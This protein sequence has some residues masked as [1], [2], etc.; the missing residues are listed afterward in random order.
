MQGRRSGILLHISSLPSAYGVGDLGPSAYKFVDFLSETKQNYWQI[1]PLNPTDSYVDNSPYHS[2]SAFAFNPL[3]ISP[4]IMVQDGLL[5]KADLEPVPAFPKGEIDYSQ[6][7]A[8]KNKLFQKAYSRFSGSKH[9]AF[10]EFCYENS[11]WL[12]DY[13]LFVALKNH[14]GKKNWGEWPLDIRTRQKQTI[15]SMKNELGDA[16]NK[17]KFLQY[18]FYA[19]WKA[20]KK[21]C[22]EKGIHIVGDIPIYVTYDSA[23]IWTNRNLFK[24]DENDKPLYVAGVPPDYFSKTGQLWGN[25]VYNWEMLKRT[26]YDWWLNR[27]DHN[28]HL[29]DVIRIDHFRGLVG[30]W[31]VP[32]HE[33]TA[34]NG[35]W[36]TTPA[37][38]FFDRL[39]RKFPCLP[40]IAEDLGVITAD[41]REIISKFGFY[42][43]KILMFAF[44]EDMP[45]HDY[46]PHN[47]NRRCVLYTGT[48]DNNPIKGWL[49]EEVSEADR[50]RI[51]SYF[52]RKVSDDELHWELIRLAM[53]SVA[54][55]VIFPVQDLLGLGKEARMNRPGTREG[56]WRWKLQPNQITA[57]LKET[58]LSMSEIYGRT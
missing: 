58:L 40:I 51:F 38:D 46:I 8:Y 10:E 37:E 14:I 49:E 42:N 29:F 27:I 43:M 12:D 30:Y 6:A 31:E 19:Q 57:E 34:M 20:L 48:H 26:N 53:R 2:I 56:N 16:I 50:Q 41:V 7:I 54:N 33:E 55:I 3:L 39:A 25:P 21:Y 24:L 35:E 1:L 11:Q 9:Y 32:A 28:L 17:E 52:G 13:T 23:D 15:D 22:K 47:L 5:K 18:I 36:I 44:G 45:H 4:K